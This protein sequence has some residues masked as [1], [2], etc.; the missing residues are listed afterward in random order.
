MQAVILAAGKGKRL[1]PFTDT[2]SKAMAPI[3]GK[4][5]VHRVID[6]IYCAGIKDFVVVIAPSDIELK[7]YLLKKIPEIQISIAYQ[8]EQ[9]GMGHALKCAMDFVKNDFLVSACDT[10]VD[11][12]SVT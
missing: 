11:N 5:I 8:N 12:E 4:P 3:A 6:K 7:K 10:L 1:K 9:L 2:H